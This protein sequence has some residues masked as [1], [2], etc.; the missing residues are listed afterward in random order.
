M[1]GVTPDV[2]HTS[3]DLD[4]FDQSLVPPIL[5][6][7]D[8][9]S[10]LSDYAKVAW[11]SIKRTPITR[12]LPGLVNWAPMESPMEGYTVVIAAMHRLWPVVV[13]NLKLISKMRRS[14]MHEVIVVVDVDEAGL[15]ELLRHAIDRLREAGL[16]IRMLHYSDAQ[17]RV[18]RSIQWGWV[19]SWMSWSIGIG[20]AETK[21]V[22]LHDLDAL[23]IDEG[24]FERL[25]AAAEK[26][27]SQFQGIRAYRANGVTAEM[28]LVTTFELVLD[29]EWVRANAEPHEGFN[30]ATVV[31]GRYVDFD[32]WLAVQHRSPV[33][34]LEPVSADALVHPSQLICQ[35][36]DHVA[37]RGGRTSPTNRLPILAYFVHLGDP[38]FSLGD[39]AFAI[40]DSRTRSATMWGR[41]T[42]IGSIPAEGWAWMEK[43]IRR[44]EQHLY[45]AT[46]PEIEDYLEGFKRRAG[47]KRTV[48]VEILAEGGVEDR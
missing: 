48:G 16:P 13:A 19:Y 2:S 24:L 7:F 20:A 43:Q 26:T 12:R 15:P 30:Q 33:R 31:D 41:E 6:A 21:R 10:P 11:K 28:N 25:Y 9:M 40:A 42:D 8:S 37:G 29:A 35:F 23:P 4:D 46:R 36:T 18:A 3:C 5:L 39:L 44:L 17:L 1:W 32:T 47:D 27:G 38:D 34:T 14:S 22:I 45:G